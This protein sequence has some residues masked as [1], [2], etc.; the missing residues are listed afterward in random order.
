[1]GAV[2]AGEHGQNFDQQRTG[3]TPDRAGA[4]HVRGAPNVF[5]TTLDDASACGHPHDP[6]LATF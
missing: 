1:M 3:R 6:T 4:E 2:L 5:V